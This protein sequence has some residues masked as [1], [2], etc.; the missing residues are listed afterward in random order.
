MKKT[1]ITRAIDEVGRIVLPKELRATMDL[2]T[3][4]ELDISVE[5]DRIILRKIQPSC[6]FCGNSENLVE[7]KENKI[8]SNCIA[9]IAKLNK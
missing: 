3:K 7:F 4:D 6:I 5:G 1:G 9:E 8:C 2:N